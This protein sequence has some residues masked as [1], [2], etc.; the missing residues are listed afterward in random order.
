VGVKAGDWPYGGLRSRGE[1]RHARRHD[2]ERGSRRQAREAGV[3]GAG[4]GVEVAAGER[5]LA[6]PEVGDVVI[7]ALL[8][9]ALGRLQV[10]CVGRQGGQ[11]AMGHPVALAP[12]V[13]VEARCRRQRREHARAG[14]R[15]VA[16][17]VEDRTAEVP[18]LHPAEGGA[19]ALRGGEPLLLEEQLTPVVA[20]PGGQE[21]QV[22]PNSA[23]TH[24]PP[25]ARPSCRARSSEVR[26]SS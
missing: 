21:R 19:V 7:A 18:P 13:G 24:S 20:E 15:C 26:A 11:R 3:E 23:A 2:V 25:E 10:T 8:E 16:V 17:A 22:G 6:T 12:Y 14:A 9:V 5:H 4:G 1:E